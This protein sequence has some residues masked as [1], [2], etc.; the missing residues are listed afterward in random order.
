LVTQ[1]GQ[2]VQAALLEPGVDIATAEELID[3][4]GLRISS[5]EAHEDDKVGMAK[6]A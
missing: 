4:V 1:K 2:L 6:L 3:Q 5:S